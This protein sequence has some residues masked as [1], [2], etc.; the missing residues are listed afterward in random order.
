MMAGQGRVLRACMGRSQQRLQRHE[1]GFLRWGAPSLY[2]RPQNL[3]LVVLDDQIAPV[4]C[5]GGQEPQ[6]LVGQLA[7]VL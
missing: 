3:P 2:F 4:R 5:P 1:S 7:H 6:L